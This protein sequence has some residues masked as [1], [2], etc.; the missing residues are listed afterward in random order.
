PFAP[1]GHLDD[2]LEYTS[3]L[4]V[5]TGCGTL[6]PECCAL[7]VRGGGRRELTGAVLTTRIARRT[8]HLA[9]VAVDPECQRRGL[10]RR[11]VMAALARLWARGF[12]HASLLVSENNTQAFA[13]YRRLGFEETGAFLSAW[14][15]M[16]GRAMALALPPVAVG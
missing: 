8:G 12:T 15:V 4:I 13:L 14:R 7:E 9:Q 1:R 10:G 5:Q 11:L 6:L 16:S 3:E 2:W